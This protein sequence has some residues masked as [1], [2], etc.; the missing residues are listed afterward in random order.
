MAIRTIQRLNSI[1]TAS[2]SKIFNVDGRLLFAD[3]EA[4]DTFSPK[5]SK[6]NKL[7]VQIYNGDQ[8]VTVKPLYDSK[9]MFYKSAIYGKNKTAQKGTTFD[10]QDI[11]AH[12][13]T[14][15]LSCGIQVDD[16]LY[17]LQSDT[18][19]NGHA[20]LATD[21]YA[22]LSADTG[23]LSI[24]QVPIST[25]TYNRDVI[26]DSA[27]IGELSG[28]AIN[29]TL[30]GIQYNT[31][32]EIPGNM[33]NDYESGNLAANTFKTKN[34]YDSIYNMN[35]STLVLNNA[36]TYVDVQRCASEVYL[37][38]YDNVN[39]K[40]DSSKPATTVKATQAATG[41]YGMHFPH[42]EVIDNINRYAN[43]PGHKTTLYGLVVRS[44]I[45]E[46][47]DTHTTI[48]N[49]QLSNVNLE[50]ANCVRD[51]AECLA[52]AHTQLFKVTIV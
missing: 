40:V 10:F 42:I 5:N 17:L 39:Y 24:G 6:Y 30:R 3:V 28:D 2:A 37:K 52:P 7:G 20:N 45:T 26:E 23:D 44:P 43:R 22:F 27:E 8:A 47:M 36:R 49:T 33:Y 29:L 46:Y 13:L 48:T 31:L 11:F 9:K 16:T 32:F 34:Q 51:I 12:Q 14:N 25:Y 21:S 50:I 18:T 1:C 35:H 38:Y 15:D 41:L 4:E 19:S